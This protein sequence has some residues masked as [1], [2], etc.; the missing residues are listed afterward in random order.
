MMVSRQTH[1]HTDTQTHKQLLNRRA[2]SRYTTLQMSEYTTI[3]LHA[4]KLHNSDTQLLNRRAASRYTTLEISLLHRR[5]LPAPPALRQP[6]Q[7]ATTRSDRREHAKLVGSA[8]KQ[9]PSRSWPHLSTMGAGYLSLALS[10]PRSLSLSLSLSRSLSLSLTLSR[11]LSLS[12]SLS[13]SK[14]Q[15]SCTQH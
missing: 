3:A 1:R 13:L 11:S 5:S 7:S 15:S 12:H 2:A 6:S 14:S 4:A 8:S 9:P 10:L